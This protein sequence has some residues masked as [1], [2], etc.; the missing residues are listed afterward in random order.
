MEQQL[1]YKVVRGNLIAH[2][3]NNAKLTTFQ[4]QKIVNC[5]TIDMFKLKILK[6]LTDGLTFEQI[7]EEFYKNVVSE[8]VEMEKYIY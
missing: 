6:Y 5:L 1:N 4:K 7:K 3:F 2:I 8:Y